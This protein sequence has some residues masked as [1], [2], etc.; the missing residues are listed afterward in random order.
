MLL[1]DVSV[2]SKPLKLS[3]NWLFWIAIAHASL[4]PSDHE[5]IW[6]SKKSPEDQQAASKGSSVWSSNNCRSIKEGSH[7]TFKYVFMLNLPIFNISSSTHVRLLTGR[8][9]SLFNKPWSRLPL[10]KR[11]PFFGKSP[12]IRTLSQRGRLFSLIHQGLVTNELFQPSF[13]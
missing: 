10:F 8:G 5:W 1:V 3:I 13:E 9:L 4:F 6:I 12:W 7:D 11:I 2:V